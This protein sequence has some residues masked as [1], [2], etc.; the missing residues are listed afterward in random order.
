MRIF[1]KTCLLSAMV[2][3]GAGAALSEAHAVDHVNRQ[4]TD[5][6]SPPD[7]A[8]QSDAQDGTTPVVPQ[9]SD[10]D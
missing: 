1:V 4:I 3:L 5:I 9:E 2:T 7:A 10:Q 8:V 6:V